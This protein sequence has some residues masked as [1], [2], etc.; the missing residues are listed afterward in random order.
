MRTS[1]TLASALILL[2]ATTAT[3]SVTA[4]TPCEDCIFAAIYATS[5]TCDAQIFTNPL[6]GG[7]LTERQKSC[8]CPLASSDTWLQQCVKPEL[9][10]AKIVSDQLTG[11]KGFQAEACANAVAPSSTTTATT[12]PTMT[13]EKPP[14]SATTTT[15]SGGAS[16][17]PNNA[18]SRLDS[19]SKVAV[20]AVVAAFAALL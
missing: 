3:N 6:Q 9:C 20:G 8:F 7:P 5:P 4:T 16:S 19:S 11:F 1:I 2:L 12:T 13:T 17:T 15:A 14:S 10:T 18:G